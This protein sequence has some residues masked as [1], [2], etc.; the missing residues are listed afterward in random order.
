MTINYFLIE[1]GYER[2]LNK[3]QNYVLYMVLNNCIHNLKTRKFWHIQKRKSLWFD[4]VNL[5]FGLFTKN[6]SVHSDY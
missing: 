2:T 4:L 5:G 6:R 1:M 3:L